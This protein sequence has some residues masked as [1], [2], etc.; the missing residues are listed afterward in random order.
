[1]LENV[2][3]SPEFQFQTSRSR[4][5]GGQNVNKVETRVELIFNI[6]SSALLTDL[7]KERISMK[8]ANRIDQ[9]GLLHVTAE[10]YRSQLKNKEL[11]I[12][13]FYDLLEKALIEPKPRKPSKPGKAA[14]E[15]RLKEKRIN[16]QKKQDRRLT[17]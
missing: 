17:D 3:F 8:L 6:A 1:M 12:Q 13:K 2:D 4:G 16:S 5:A 14:K 9:A 10:Q 15:K 7:Q 11:A